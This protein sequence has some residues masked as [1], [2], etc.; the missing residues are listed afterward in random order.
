MK[1]YII[2]KSKKVNSKNCESIL[3]KTVICFYSQH[4]SMTEVCCALYKYENESKIGS[5]NQ[6]TT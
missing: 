5:N 3:Y 1:T 6:L 2:G 4:N